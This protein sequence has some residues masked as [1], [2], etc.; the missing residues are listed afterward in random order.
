MQNLRHCQKST[1]L[2]LFLTAPDTQQYCLNAENHLTLLVHPV[3]LFAELALNL[4]TAVIRSLWLQ[5]RPGMPDIHTYP[6]ARTDRLV[7]RTNRCVRATFT[8]AKR[9]PRTR[10][11][12]YITHIHL[13]Q[14][15]LLR[16]PSMPMQSQHA[17]AHH[18]HSLSCSMNSFTSRWCLLS[19]PMIFRTWSW[20][21]ARVSNPSTIGPPLLLPCPSLTGPINS[22]QSSLSRTSCP[23]PACCPVLR[24]GSMI[25]HHGKAACK[26]LGHRSRSGAAARD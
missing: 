1:V 20:S 5:L 21:S 3:T 18:A 25:S 13:E 9:C 4:Q 12:Q 6:G 15:V 7:R 8:L 2:K 22:L 14:N 11:M 23:S 19:A 10:D 24:N 26:T 17:L 16:Q